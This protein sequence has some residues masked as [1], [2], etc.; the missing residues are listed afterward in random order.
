MRILRGLVIFGAGLIAGSLGMQSLIA[1]QSGQ[2]SHR[3]NHVGVRA[4]DFQQSLDFYTRVLGFKLSYKFPGPEGMPTTTELQVN[5][6]TFVELAPPAPNQPPGLT[7]FAIY[8]DNAEATVAQFRRAGAMVDDA[9]LRSNTGA[10]VSG[11]MDPNGIRIEII[12]LPAD[13]PMRKALDAY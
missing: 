6:D 12:E 3:I 10:R 2:K 11:V 13:S 5:K 7:H 1:Q 9:T 4:K 8:T